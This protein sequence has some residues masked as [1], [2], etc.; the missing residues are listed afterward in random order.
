MRTVIFFLLAVFL[1]V[2]QTTVLQLGPGWFRAPDLVFILVSFI[3]YRFDW[4]RGLM[5]V[6]GCGWMMDVVAAS[7]PG[8][9]VF[10]YLL[11]FLALS[12][13]AKN[14]PVKE[15][16]YQIPLVGL[17]YFVTQV[18]VYGVLTMIDSESL[19][20]WSWGRLTRETVI[21]VAA[22]IPGF[23]LFNVLYEYL[24]QRRAVSRIIHRK[25]GNRFR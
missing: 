15:S 23:A 5:L 10:E 1:V 12:V 21:V 17:V 9:F 18:L 19:P 24:Q 16:A 4:L 7:S 22:T 2:L 8:V 3:A 6:F 13:L 11:V 14:S 25:S 20:P